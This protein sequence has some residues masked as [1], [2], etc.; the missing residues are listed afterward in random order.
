[1]WVIVL[2]VSC[3][4]E[5][6]EPTVTCADPVTANSEF[7]PTVVVSAKNC[8]LS[9]ASNVSLAE[10]LLLPVPVLMALMV[11][12]FIPEFEE[13]DRVQV[14]F[15]EPR[16]PSTLTI[17][18][19][20]AVAQAS[21][22]RTSVAR[23]LAWRSGEVMSLSCSLYGPLDALAGWHVGLFQ[24]RRCRYRR[25]RRRDL[26]DGPADACTSQLIDSQTPHRHD[27]QEFLSLVP[28]PPRNHQPIE[29]TVDLG[30]LLRQ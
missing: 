2:V 6:K 12:P 16:T 19:A 14:V 11:L 8:P 22:R 13:P 18:A 24:L 4:R 26:D 17:R 21:V 30:G 1:M 27:L 7:S 3:V 28:R 23:R 15:P 10:K 29:N 25:V 5:P 9:E 20:L